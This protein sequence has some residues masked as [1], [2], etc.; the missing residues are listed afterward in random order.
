MRDFILSITP[1]MSRIE[2]QHPNNKSPEQTR[3]ALEEVAGKLQARF[4]VNHHWDGDTLALNGSGLDGR[5]AMQPGALQVTAE[6]GFL[7]SAMKGPIESE[8][9]RVLEEKFA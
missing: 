4:G 3:Q 1:H 8:I 9:R 5:I 6:L 7:L 2:L